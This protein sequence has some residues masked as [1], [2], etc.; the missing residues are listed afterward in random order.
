MSLDLCIENPFLAPTTGSEFWENL[1]H[2][3]SCLYQHANPPTES[4]YYSDMTKN[5]WKCG[6]EDTCCDWRR[7]SATSFICQVGVTR[8]ASYCSSLS[9]PFLLLSFLFDGSAQFLLLSLSYENWGKWISHSFSFSNCVPT[10]SLFYFIFGC[11][12]TCG[13]SQ[14]RDRIWADKTGSLT[15][16][17]GSGVEL[18]PQQGPKSLQRQRWI[19]NPLCYH[20]NA[21]AWSWDDTV[22]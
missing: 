22:L 4:L 14:A 18:I 20:R 10:P 11:T 7:L 12:H 2:Q 6:K 15:H 13:S 17:T 1:R 9:V 19:L 8:E 21:P 5:T 3:E 16:C